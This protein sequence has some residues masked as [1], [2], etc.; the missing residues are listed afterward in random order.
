MKRTLSLVGLFFIGLGLL[1]NPLTG[2]VGN[3]E[4]D[5]VAIPAT[6]PVLTTG[7][8]PP[9]PATTTSTSP[10]PSTTSSTTGPLETTTTSSGTLTVVGP[11][12]ETEWGRFQVEIVI[13]DG[14]LVAAT[15]IQEP[16]DRRSRRINDQ[17]LP[18]YE[19]LAIEAQS[20]DIDV[21]SGATVTW[22]GYTTSLQAAL[23]EA[24]LG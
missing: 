23:D 9:E 22:Q 1:F 11:A 5:T 8:P 14:T 17:A 24:G 20:A 3:A 12:V 18:W 10:T 13:E 7:E 2:V 19:E 6:A 21:I 4:S 16:G 15:A